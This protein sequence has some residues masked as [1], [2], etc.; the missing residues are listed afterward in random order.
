MSFESRIDREMEQ[1]RRRENERKTEQLSAAVDLLTPKLSDFADSP[2]H[3]DWQRDQAYVDRTE[4]HFNEEPGY[5]AK[6][7]EHIIQYGIAQGRILSDP[8]GESYQTA[9][10]WTTRFDDISNRIDAAAT[11]YPS[12][13]EDGSSESN[14]GITFGIDLT[15]N[16]DPDT[17]RRKILVGSNSARELPAGFS[18]IVYYRDP[19]G[20]RSQRSYIPR[21]CIGLDSESVDSYLDGL[22]IDRNGVPHVRQ[23]T[24]AVPSFKILYEMSRQNEL[25]ESPLYQKLDDGI[26]TPDEQIALSR[27]EQLDNIY[28][29]ELDRIAKTLPE[30]LTKQCLTKSGTIDV[31]KV[32]TY[33]ST[34]EDADQTFTNIIQTTE[35]LLNE[36]ASS[37]GEMG[38]PDADYLKKAGDRYRRQPYHRTQDLGA[39]ATR[40][41][42][43]LHA[44]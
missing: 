6:A 35:S 30:W 42:S 23:G 25:F 29:Q 32:A 7:L 33:L 31:P 20:E 17:I 13:S 3:P 14:S 5:H 9:P 15:T 38:A 21:Y 2:A 19:N 1:S 22:T 11:V 43:K 10:I 8:T 40:L 44:S 37:S 16:P 24:D 39:R 26:A 18:Q 28:L 4:A 41:A 27:M 34:G 36:F 12:E